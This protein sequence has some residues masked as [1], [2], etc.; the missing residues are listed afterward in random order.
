MQTIPELEWE[1][2]IFYYCFAEE[3][4]GSERLGNLPDTAQQPEELK[5]EPNLKSET[6]HLASR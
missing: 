5:I 2:T 6:H 3:N 1:V 4:T